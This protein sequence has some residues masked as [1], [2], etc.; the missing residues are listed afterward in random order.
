VGEKL[1][2]HWLPQISSDLVNMGVTQDP[3]TQPT[4]TRRDLWS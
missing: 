4:G 3:D 1:Q 2:V